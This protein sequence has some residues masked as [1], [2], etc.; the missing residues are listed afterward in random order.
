M[1]KAYLTFIFSILFMIISV[2][3]QEDQVYGGVVARAMF[4]VFPKANFAGSA[5]PFLAVPNVCFDAP[6]VDSFRANAAYGGIL[7][8]FK[9]KK[10][11]GKF[12]DFPLTTT[13]YYN[14]YMYLGYVPKTMVYLPDL[15]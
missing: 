8:I 13:A 12:F 15:Y 5:A 2:H 6:V 4:T 11:T 1:F 9:N 10:C 7:R 14:L 3:S